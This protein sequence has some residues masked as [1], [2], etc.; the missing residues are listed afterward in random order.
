VWLFTVAHGE[1]G[2][3]RLVGHLGAAVEVRLP[4]FSGRRAAGGR[5]AGMASEVRLL[6]FSGKACGQER[7]ST[8]EEEKLTI[9][10]SSPAARLEEEK[11]GTVSFKTT[12]FRFFFF[13]YETASFWIK[14][15]VS[16]KS[17]ARTRQV[18]NQP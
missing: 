17:G 7:G 3:R 5:P 13:K 16:F 1:Q 11:R 15:A 9:F 12:P 10:L 4:R 6:R 14:R 8:L 2:L 18:S